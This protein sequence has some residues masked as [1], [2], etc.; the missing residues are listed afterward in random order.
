MNHQHYNQRFSFSNRC[1]SFKSACKGLFIVFRTQH[2]AWIELVASAL[3]IAAGFS[4]KIT[5]IEWLAIVFSICI[6]IVTEIINTS[7]EY[8][9]NLVSPTYNEIAG[10]VKDIASAAVLFASIISI[11]VAIIIFFP[12]LY[13]FT[14]F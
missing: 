11:I 12:Y 1:Q 6:V 9:T 4:F 13:E 14:N 2:N 7:I 5:T 8:L 10:K 3:V